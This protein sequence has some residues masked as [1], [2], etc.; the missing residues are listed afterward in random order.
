MQIRRCRRSISMVFPHLNCSFTLTL[1][2][3]LQ[4][5]R[6]G[7]VV[8][9]VGWLLNVPGAF[10]CVRVLFLSVNAWV[11]CCKLRLNDE[12]PEAILAGSRLSINLINAIIIIA[13]VMRRMV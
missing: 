6:H 13:V 1:S 11:L 5:V 9:F 12:K 3:L 2:R 7:S 8:L 10:Q 4:V